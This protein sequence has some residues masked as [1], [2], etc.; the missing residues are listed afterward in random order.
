MKKR[1]GII[2]NTQAKKLVELIAEVENWKEEMK[3]APHFEWSYRATR[4][5]RQA[6]HALESALLEMFPEV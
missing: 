3:N 1:R 6:K 4:E 5:L 2:T